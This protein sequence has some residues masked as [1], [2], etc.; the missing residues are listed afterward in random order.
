[1]CV[2]V[3]DVPQPSKCS[4]RSRTEL[5]SQSSSSNCSGSGMCACCS[6]IVSSCAVCRA[7]YLYVCTSFSLDSQ[8][9]EC[10]AVLVQLCTVLYGFSPQ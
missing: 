7:V 4:K 5:P 3:G 10:V 9:P 1:M 6:V 8:C 2:C